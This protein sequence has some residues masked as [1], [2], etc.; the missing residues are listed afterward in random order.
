MET[1]IVAANVYT[2][3][4][5]SDQT[6]YEIYLLRD[7]RIFTRT[8]LGYGITDSSYILNI[9]YT[10]CVPSSYAFAFV[11]TVRDANSQYACTISSI[12]TPNYDACYYDPIG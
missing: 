12:Q 6:N 2:S 7:G 5:K 1:D 9:D 11:A 10:I 8:H 3:T 4:F